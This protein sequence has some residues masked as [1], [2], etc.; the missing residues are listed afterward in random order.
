MINELAGIRNSL[1]KHRNLENLKA[2]E[3]Y[4]GIELSIFTLEAENISVH[5]AA[6]DHHILE[7]NYCRL[8]RIGWKMGNGNSVYLGQKDFSL[9]TLKACADS[10]MPLP[11]GTYEVSRK[12]PDM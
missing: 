3:L 9:H 4:P 5:H 10:V 11:N 8:G 7:I 12:L 2:V 6:L 1:S